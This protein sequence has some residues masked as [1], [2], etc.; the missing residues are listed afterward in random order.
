MIG[1]QSWID[2]KGFE[3]PLRSFSTAPDRIGIWGCFYFCA[4]IA[5]YFRA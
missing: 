1:I 5:L 2:R 4:Q 3:K